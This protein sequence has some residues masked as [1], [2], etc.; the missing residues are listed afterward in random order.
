MRL[1][2][3]IEIA[4]YYTKLHGYFEVYYSYSVAVSRYKLFKRRKI[5]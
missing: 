5:C 4:D 3:T 1:F 2:A